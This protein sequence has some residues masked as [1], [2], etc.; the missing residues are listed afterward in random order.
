LSFHLE[1]RPAFDYADENWNGHRRGDRHL[2][3]FEAAPG[4]APLLQFWGS[5]SPTTPLSDV[6]QLQSE[7]GGPHRL[8]V[9][10]GAQHN[11]I[12]EPVRHQFWGDVEAFLNEGSHHESS[13]CDLFTAKP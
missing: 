1:C 10:E 6:E 8:V 7:Y 13:L 12:L 11:L 5:D 9:Y 2:L 3:F 4:R